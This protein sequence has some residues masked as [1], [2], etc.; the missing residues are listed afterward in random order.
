[1]LKRIDLETSLATTT[2]FFSGSKKVPKVR[3]LDGIMNEHMN[4]KN[5]KRM[6][7]Y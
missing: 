4:H 7:E 6:S 1:M 3:K 2:M 5:S